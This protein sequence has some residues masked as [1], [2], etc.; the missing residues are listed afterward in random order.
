[1]KRL[2]LLRHGKSDWDESSLSDFDRPLRPRGR[3]D[4]VR[5]GEHLASLDLAPDLIV[6]SPAARAR[7]TAMLFAEALGYDEDIEWDKRIYGANSVELMAVLCQLPDD[8]D[9][10]VLIGHNPGLE[11]LVVRLAAGRPDFAMA[12]VRLPTAAAAHIQLDLSSWSE[13]RAGCGRLEWIVTP[14]ELAQESA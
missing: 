14:A 8:V 5:M 6:C 4:A 10:V 1:M 9:H 3:R 11:E 12:G 13:A 2:T 7:Q